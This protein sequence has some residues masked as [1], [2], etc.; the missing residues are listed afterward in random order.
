MQDLT[1]STAA[2]E[3]LSAV[4]LM[5]MGFSRAIAYSLFH[6]PDFPT[7]RIGK[8]LFVRRDRLMEW[9]ESHEDGKEIN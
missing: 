3:M 6:R 7:V 9:L 1:Y 8:R 5:G 2:R 4:D